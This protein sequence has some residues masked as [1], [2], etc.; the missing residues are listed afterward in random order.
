MRNEAWCARALIRSFGRL[1]RPGS[2]SVGHLRLFT[3]EALKEFLTYY[4]FE[5]VNVV[6]APCEGLPKVLSIIDRNLSKFS[7]LSL[8][9]IVVTRKNEQ[10]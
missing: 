2:F 3:Y 8:I 4:R 5:I 6:G 10:G 1:G 9:V 7:S